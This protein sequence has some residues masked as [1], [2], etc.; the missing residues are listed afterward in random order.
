MLPDLDLHHLGNPEL[1]RAIAVRASERVP[2]LRRHL[3]QAGISDAAA[4]AWQDLPQTD[5]R[6]YLLAH[7]F[8]DLLGDDFSATYTVFGSSGSSGQPFYWPQLRRDQ[9]AI[10]ARLRGLL[11]E[12]FRIHERRTLVII[13]LALG[14]WIGGEHLS[15]VMKSLAACSA[16]PLAVFSPGNHH[17]EIIRMIGSAG[18]HVDQILLVV[19][20]SAIGHLRLRAEQQGAAL[21]LARMRYLVIGEPFPESLRL[22]LRRETGIPASDPVL[23]SIFGSADTGVL[24]AESPA[25]AAMRSL[26]A[27]DPTLAADLGFTGA[28]PHLFHLA[29]D[30][31]FLESCAGELC[32]TR[33]QGIPLLRYNLHDA[34]RLLNWSAA[35]AR[36]QARLGS[37]HPLS[38]QL[39]AT[40]DLPD[41]VAV[42]GRADACLMLCGTNLSEAMLDTAIRDPSLAPWLTGLY[43]ARLTTSRGRQRLELA[44][45]CRSGSAADA[46]SME[47][48]YPLLV[49]ALGRVQPEFLDDWQSIYRRWDGDP[50]LRIL[51][52]RPVAWPG[53]ADSGSIKQRG[54]R[55]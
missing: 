16:Y 39:A 37:D 41:L 42:S 24:G 3:A 23:L 1:G 6:G 21:P 13:G 34:V 44:L 40:R 26:A 8:E 27:A 35:I 18:R 51:D 55:L 15:W 32:V 29:D 45:E 17:D 9:D 52:L 5:K 38:V 31:V 4:T 22:E 19:C 30:D 10:A 53:L 47:A 25:S 33:W 2:A 49:A 7:P 46:A 28:V 20:P 48:V 54:I 43:R 36:V 14:S 11:E 50:D 12:S